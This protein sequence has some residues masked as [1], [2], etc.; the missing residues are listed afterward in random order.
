MPH[1]ALQKGSGD[2]YHHSFGM[3]GTYCV[4]HYICILLINTNNPIYIFDINGRKQW[5]VCLPSLTVSNGELV[6]AL[7][8]KG[9][10]QQYCQELMWHWWKF[11]PHMVLVETIGNSTFLGNSSLLEDLGC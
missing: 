4:Q 6:S 8:D 10:A 1:G 11:S 2:D 9:C 5:R 3:E 7:A